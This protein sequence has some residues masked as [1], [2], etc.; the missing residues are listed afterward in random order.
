MAEAQNADYVFPDWFLNARVKLWF[1]PLDAEHRKVR[2]Y[3]TMVCVECDGD[4]ATC[5]ICGRTSEM[6]ENRKRHAGD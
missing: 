2:D 4:V 5:L 3:K 1:C 6:H